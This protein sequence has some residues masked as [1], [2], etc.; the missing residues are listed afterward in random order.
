MKNFIL[1]VTILCGF[2]LNSSIIFADESHSSDKSKWNPGRPDSHAPIGVM[3]EHTHGANEYMLS[4]RFMS[5][6][7]NGHRQGSHSLSSA[8]VFGLDYD[9]AALD[10]SM[11]MHMFGFMYAPS[12]EL[13]FMG[14]F[15]FVENSMNMLH[16]PSEMNMGDNM[17]MDMQHHGDKMNHRSSGIGDISIGSLYKFYDEKNQRAH[18]N[19]SVVLPTAGVEESEH[20]M[21]LPYGMQLGSGTWDLR[22]G[23]TWLGQLGSFSYGAQVMATIRLEDEN[24]AGYALGDCLDTTAWL[25]QQLTNGLSASVRL[26]YTKSDPIEGHFHNAHNHNSP[27]FLKANYGRDFVEGGIGLNWQFKKGAFK[28][29]RLA[30]EGIFP[31]DQDPNGVGMDHDYT[32]IAGWQFAF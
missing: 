12:D 18:L 28:G 7:M 26:S 4:Y 3:G 30:I 29:H 14:M 21:L 22:P 32:V 16:K 24:D 10:M 25:A 13:T 6:E 20:G 11:D 1:T 27:T 8:D 23:I 31:L 17:G 2:T 19:I 15:N 5:M 9:I